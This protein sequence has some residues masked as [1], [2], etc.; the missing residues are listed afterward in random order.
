MCFVIQLE[1]ER[2]E[3]RSQVCLLKEGK[4]AV[5]EELKARSTV[6]VQNAEEAVQQRAESNALRFVLSVKLG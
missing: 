2:L 6:M 1:R 5:E 3:L 4:E